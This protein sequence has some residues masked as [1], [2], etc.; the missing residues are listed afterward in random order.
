[1]KITQLQLAL[2]LALATHT[3]I[4]YVYMFPEPRMCTILSLND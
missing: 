4:K 3:G 2:I 1:M